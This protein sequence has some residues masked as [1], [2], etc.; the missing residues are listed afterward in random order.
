[1]NMNEKTQDEKIN[2]AFRNLHKNLVDEI[3][4][5]FRAY[6]IEADEVVLSIDGLKGSIKYGAWC[7]CT[8][9]SL[10]AYK[11]DINK[12]HNVYLESI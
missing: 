11:D 7:P 2:Y 8:D 4:G 1:M 12:V 10:I 6:G 9:S 3:C 5:F